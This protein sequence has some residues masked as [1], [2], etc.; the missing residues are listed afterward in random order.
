MKVIDWLFGPP[1][2][3]RTAK[4]IRSVNFVCLLA[5]G[6]LAAWNHDTFTI[7][8]MAVY[9]FAFLCVLWSAP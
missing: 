2:G 8:V 7:K 1:P 4:V 9:Y 3:S 5:V 6:M